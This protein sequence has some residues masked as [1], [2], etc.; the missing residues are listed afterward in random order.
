MYIL[1]GLNESTGA[2][3]I[4]LLLASPLGIK[5]LQQSFLYDGQATVRQVILYMD[6]PCHID[7]LSLS[8]IIEHIANGI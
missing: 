5:G 8:I 3:F 7:H 6:R 1:A 2:I 4:T